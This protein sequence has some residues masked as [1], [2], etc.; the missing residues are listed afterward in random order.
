MHVATIIACTLTLT[1]FCRFA[2]VAT[3]GLVARR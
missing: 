2:W 3:L 1:L